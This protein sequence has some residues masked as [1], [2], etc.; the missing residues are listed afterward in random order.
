MKKVSTKSTIDVLSRPKITLWW[1]IIDKIN[2]AGTVKHIDATADPRHKFIDFCSLFLLAD[3]I[4]LIPS[5][6]KTNKA[7]IK[8]LNW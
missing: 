5:G 8:P 7:T 3:L 4:A 6:V 2:T 1:N